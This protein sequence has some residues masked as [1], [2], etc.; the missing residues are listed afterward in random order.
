MLRRYTP[1]KQ[2]RGTVIPTMLRIEVYERDGYCVGRQVGFPTICAGRL[3]LDHVRASHGIGMKSETSKANLVALC[4][5]CHLWKTTHGRFAR[6]M[7][8]H[9][10]GQFEDPHAA[11]VDPCGPTCRP[12][13][14]ID[15]ERGE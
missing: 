13:W 1:L 3:E 5:N 15:H 10:L 14:P 4:S 9:Y 11:H 2:S 8:L 7:L 12:N 6:T